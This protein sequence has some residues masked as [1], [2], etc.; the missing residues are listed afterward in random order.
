MK[1]YHILLDFDDSLK[2]PGT[3]SLSQAF[4][5]ARPSLHS[6][7]HEMSGQ[8]KKLDFGFETGVHMDVPDEADSLFKRRM[9]ALKEKGVVVG[10]GLV[11]AW[12]SP[13]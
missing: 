8:G 5:A 11:P 2:V 1:R 6:L 13:N 4:E 3:E 12:S 9:G 10:Y 7:W